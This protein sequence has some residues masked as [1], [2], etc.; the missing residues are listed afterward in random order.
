[1]SE[2]D[3]QP[4]RL[5]AAL[6]DHG[7]EGIALLTSEPRPIILAM[8]YLIIGLLVAV[9]VWSFIGRA[10]VI[11][12]AQGNLAPE[13]DVRRVYAPV[14][15]ELVDIYM[16]EGLP[17]SQGDVLAR[18]NS[19]TAIEAA[20]RSLEAKNKLIEA[21]QKYKLFPAE[22][23][24]MERK[25]E[26][27]KA[28][29]EAEEKAH[30][31]RMRESIAK[32]AERQRLKLEK[33]RAL[34]EK[35]RK[36]ME[37][38][39]S[40]WQSMERLF[41]SPG[42][43][44]ISKQRLDQAKKD[45]ESKRV[46]Y[47][48]AEASLGEF[49]I[50]LNNELVKRREELQRKSEELERLYVKYEEESLKLEAAQSRAEMEVKLA[51]IAA[52]GAERVSFE[53]I[54]EENFLRVKA[55]VS[56]VLTSVA[57]TQVGDKVESKSALAGIAPQDARMILKITIPERDRGFLRE[58]MPV[59]LKFNAFPYQRY[60]FIEGTLEYIS[61]SA[62]ADQQ[63]KKLVYKGRVSLE[64]DYVVAEDKRYPLRFGMTAAAEIVVR[65]RRVIDMALDTLRKSS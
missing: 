37:L 27:L 31:R 28:R 58:G 59:K 23:K 41:K 26:A 45:Y 64:R 50:Q 16:A 57:Y 21:L 19:T 4:K 25:V 46:D 62:T 6:E 18:L 39:K 61:P 22:K 35:A 48:L 12:T 65:Q 11:V 14:Q 53:D 30:Q 54:D 49:E 60:G 9:F 7:A 20:T 3:N 52:E 15:G 32:L 42:G 17:V 43:G 1:M 63:T 40:S 10:D 33:A 51:R 24:A 56:G 34:R 8:I 44:G 55:P 2:N 13:S 29:L 5:A 36:D 38:A 47:Q